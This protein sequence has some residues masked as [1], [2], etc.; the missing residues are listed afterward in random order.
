MWLKFFVSAGLVVFAGVK[1]TKY[2]DIV[3]D[4]FSISKVWVG[5]ILL[6]VATSLPELTATIASAVGLNAPDLA[7]GNI[8]GSVNFNLMIIVV[9][10]FL[11]RKGSI[12]GQIQS[13]KTYEWSAA[14]YAVLSLIVVLEIFFASKARLIGIG[15]VSLGNILIVGIYILSSKYIFKVDSDQQAVES[16]RHKI[17]KDDQVLF[18]KI[19]LGAGAVILGG[20]WLADVCDKIAIVTGLGRTFVGTMLLGFVTSLPEIVVSVSALKM[21]ALDL[22]FGNIFGSNMFNILILSI[23]EMTYAK[24]FLFENVSKAHIMMMTLSV[25]LTT[26]LIAGIKK[27]KKK[28]FLGFGIDSILMIIC[29]AIGMNFLYHLK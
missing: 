15:S 6:G 22:A 13:K 8:A 25:V 18:I 1:L 28:E 11:Y 19:A 27:G 16:V 29:F 23:C 9:L 10:D 12:T 20:I 7:V 21:G 3:S 2:A 14:F 4:R 17:T 5:M 24:G 26:I